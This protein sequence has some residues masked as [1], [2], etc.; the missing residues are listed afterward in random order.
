MCLD[1]PT[2]LCSIGKDL[3]MNQDTREALYQS[4]KAGISNFALTLHSSFSTVLPE[5]LGNNVMVGAEDTGLLIL[6]T[7]TYKY[8]FCNDTCI[9]TGVKPRILEGIYNH[10]AVYDTILDNL[11]YTHPDG[12]DMECKLLYRSC[13]FVE[14]MI[15]AMDTIWS[16]SQARYDE[17]TPP[18]AF[19][20]CWA[21]LQQVHCEFRKV[22]QCGA[23]AIQKGSES[24]HIGATWWHV[25]QTHRKMDEFLDIF[26]KQHP[27]ITPVF[28]TH[29]DRFRVSPTSFNVTG[30]SVKRLKTDL[31]TLQ[32]A[33]NH[34]N[35]AR[36]NPQTFCYNIQGTQGCKIGASALEAM[37]KYVHVG[38]DGRIRDDGQGNQG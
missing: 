21:I 19:I 16:E 36:V 26:F 14:I 37:P 7:K 34:L 18:E 5:I 20:I 6:C 13:N 25:L 4:K 38:K 9:M 2:L 11:G 30:T 32:T 22:R 28:T 3:S 23:A 1:T 35:G 33:V 15:T 27:Y 17:A 10:R 8:W 24:Q 12:A 31:P 29:L